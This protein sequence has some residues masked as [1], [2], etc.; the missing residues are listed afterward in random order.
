M[1]L[2]IIME[3]KGFLGQRKSKLIT[4]QDFPG[5]TPCSVEFYVSVIV[6]KSLRFSGILRFSRDKIPLGYLQPKE[7]VRIHKDKR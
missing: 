5:D 4:F 2:G 1:T 7:V 3:P 6:S